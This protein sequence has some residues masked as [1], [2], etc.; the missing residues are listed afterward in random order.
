M[1]VTFDNVCDYLKSIGITSSNPGGKGIMYGSDADGVN[2]TVSQLKLI[3]INI[4]C[5]YFCTVAQ[6]DDNNFEVFELHHGAEWDDKGRYI[7]DGELWQYKIYKSLKQAIDFA[8]KCAKKGEL[9]K[10]AIKI[11]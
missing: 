5:C 6:Y 11:W 2:G 4:D 8:I 10:K 3:V 1:K 7:T 9:P